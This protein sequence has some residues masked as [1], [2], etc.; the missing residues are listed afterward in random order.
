[1]PA[2]FIVHSLPFVTVKLRSNNK[3]LVLSRVLIDTGL[4]S[5]VFRTDDLRTLDVYIDGSDQLRFMRGIGGYEA[6]VE[7]GIESIEID[8]LIATPFIIEVGAL[9]YGFQIDGILGSN[10]LLQ[11]GAQINFKTLTLEK[12]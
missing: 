7:K 6:V 8:G 9:D 11:V 3:E 1:M 4:A 2:I 10:F 5:T 12:A